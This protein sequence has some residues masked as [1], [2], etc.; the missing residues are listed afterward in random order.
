[1]ILLIFAACFLVGYKEFAGATDGFSQAAG[2][3]CVLRQVHIVPVRRFPSATAAASLGQRDDAV[4][5]GGTVVYPSAC[6][7]AGY[8]TT[9]QVDGGIAARRVVEVNGER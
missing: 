3:T 7:L 6:T 1:M 2:D 9:L 8:V 5:V 4:L